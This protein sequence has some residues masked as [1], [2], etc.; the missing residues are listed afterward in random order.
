MTRA[1]GR[2]LTVSAATAFVALAAA[3]CGPA[4]EGAP[5]YVAGGHAERGVVAVRRYG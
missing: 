1:R 3:A 2:C 5:Q 4:R